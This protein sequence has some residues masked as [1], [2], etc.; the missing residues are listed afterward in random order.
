MSRGGYS[1]DIDNWALIRWR[2]Q[3]VSAV[4]GARGQLFLKD[5]L[6]SLDAMPEKKLIAHELEKDGCHCALGAVGAAKGLPIQEIDPEDWDVVAKTFNISDVLA[7]EIAFINDEGGFYDDTPEKR[8][9][10]VR[11]WVAANIAGEVKS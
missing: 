1:D 4:R 9:S 7:R 11:A 3:V 2:G 8:W 6:V 10:R 5:L